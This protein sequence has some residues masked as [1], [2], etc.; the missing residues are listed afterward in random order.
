M[1]MAVYITVDL[2][3]PHYCGLIRYAPQA[4]ILRELN[5]AYIGFTCNQHRGDIST[6]LLALKVRRPSTAIVGES[7]PDGSPGSFPVVSPSTQ[8]ALGNV[9][10]PVPSVYVGPVPSISIPSSVGSDYGSG[11]LSPIVEVSESPRISITDPGGKPSAAE[12]REE[13]MAVGVGQFAAQLASSLFSEVVSEKPSIRAS[14]KKAGIEELAAQL[15]GSLLQDVAGKKPPSVAPQE[16]PV[17]DFA[18]CLAGSLLEGVT[19]GKPPVEKAPKQDTEQAPSSTAASVDQLASSLASSILFSV[20][21]KDARATEASVAHSATEKSIEG[22]AATLSKSI[23][24]DI[25]S[26]TQGPSR[27]PQPPVQTVGQQTSTDVALSA[28]A[29]G[30]AGSI[31]SESLSSFGE[32][33]STPPQPTIFV[34]TEKR[35]GIS[36]SPSSSRSSSLTGQSL[37]LHEFTDELVESTVRE[38]AFIAHVTKNA[39]RQASELKTEI[40]TLA[41]GLVA[42]SLQDVLGQQPKRS[43]SEGSDL[44]EELTS[45]PK[46]A[47]AVYGSHKRAPSPGRA[48][49]VGGLFRHGHHRKRLPPSAESSDVGSD[50]EGHI[51]PLLLS[52]PSSRM[53]YAWSTAST[54][55]ED[56]RPV[57]P[58]DMD[59]IA[60]GF[61][62]NVEEFA[63]LFTDMLFSEAVAET[64]GVHSYS[65]RHKAGEGTVKRACTGYPAVSSLGLFGAV[66]PHFPSDPSFFHVA[67]KM[68]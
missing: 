50:Q 2:W 57:S 64:T 66:L 53:S 68:C 31:I 38:G 36:E 39:E 14:E 15:A 42:S 51:N 17:E 6:E 10:I 5:K 18:A 4:N 13:S 58:T 59:R 30:L 21:G 62:T 23:I 26:E 28:L 48:A 16:K 47:V 1:S 7:Y 54:R 27:P 35:F 11:P 46:S 52:T 44:K 34:E 37:T 43:R 20:P 12:G 24:S 45:S 67:L 22:K 32:S 33:S 56:S 19:S 60:L 61:A 8:D 55:D 40:G 41:A 25:L 9:N 65:P 63:S 29:T 49:K 3:P